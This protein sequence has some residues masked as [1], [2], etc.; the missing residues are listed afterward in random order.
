VYRALIIDDEDII[1]QGLKKIIPWKSL[2]CE[3]IGEARNGTEGLELIRK[4]KPDIVITDIRM[5]GA[6]GLE[7]ISRMK[8][9]SKNSKIIILTGHR[10][11][12]YAQKAI[13][14]GVFRYLLKPSDKNEIIK[15]L[16]EAI[17]EI[18]KDKRYYIKEQIENTSEDRINVQNSNKSS[19][20]AKNAIEYIS[21]HYNDVDISLTKVA[22]EVF[23][24]TW[25]LSRVLK[26]ETE[27]N[28]N[29]ILNEIRIDEAKKIL[30]SDTLKIYEVAEICG[31]SD[32][33]Y[34][35]KLFKK[36][37]GCTPLEYKNR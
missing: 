22:G 27:K 2:D 18:E 21:K 7:M 33:T 29:D 20:I 9:E 34:F 17:L 24:S 30:K 15:N 11:F 14:F 37:C 36:M 4:L 19:Y 12:D 3:I 28:F 5:P 16:Q 26:Q 35:N 13:K 32:T 1:R 6:D 10:D 31:F 8:G 25:H 23:V